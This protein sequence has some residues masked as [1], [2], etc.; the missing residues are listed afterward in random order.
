M[1]ANEDAEPL[2]ILVFDTDA[3]RR[4]VRAHGLAKFGHRCEHA[5]SFDQVAGLVMPGRIDALLCAI[6]PG[7]LPLRGFTQLF[8][9]FRPVRQTALLALTMKFTH[10]QAEKL[11]QTGFDIALHEPIS[12]SEIEQAVCA[13]ALPLRGKPPLDRAL[14][15]LIRAEQGEGALEA[16]EQ[17]VQAAAEH[18]V[19][20]I[21]ADPAILAA[22]A[23]ALAEACAAAGMPAAADVAR[24]LAVQPERPYLQ[25][26]L[27]NAMAGARAAARAEKQRRAAESAS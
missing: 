9:R 1:D 17:S 15:R 21:E 6:G 27:G 14:R 5:W 22:A 18:L 20:V 4:G 23:A 10:G 16:L 12:M 26:A 24:D 7:Q 13:T 11:R 19:A 3:H 2:K 25:R 8:E